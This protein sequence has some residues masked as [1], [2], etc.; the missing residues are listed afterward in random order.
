MHRRTLLG[1][2]AAL[3]AAPLVGARAQAAN[4]K[5]VW[6]HAMTGALG[7]Q[8]DRITKEF[9]ASQNTIELTSIYKGGYADLMTAVI[10]AFRAGQAPDIAQIFEVGTENMIAAGK[11]VKTV[12]ELVKETGVHIDPNA[13]IPAV[14]GY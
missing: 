10:A 8:I 12:S 9:N 4:T 1:A 6:W 5:I 3:A 13:F 14:R 2:T 11:A 7:A